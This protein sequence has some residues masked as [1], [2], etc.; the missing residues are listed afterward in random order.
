MQAAEKAE[1]REGIREADRFYA[2]ALE[3]LG[4]AETE[5]AAEVKLGRAKTLN[6][7]GD[8]QPADDLLVRVSD[9]APSLGR[10]DLHARALI[11]RSKIAQK[12]GRATEARTY[13]SA[14]EEIAGHVG[15]RLLQVRAIYV[16]AYIRAWFE[17]A[18]EAAVE[19]ARR[20]L[21][22][23]GELNDEALQIEVGVWLLGLLY[24]LGDLAG[25]EEQAMRCFALLGDGGGLRDKARLT[26]QLGQ[27]RYHQGEIDAAEELEERA[28]EWL[29]RTGDS[30]FYVQGLRILALCAVARSDLTLAE[31]RLR[32]A[33][34]YARE[35]G[36]S[37]VIDMYRCL[38]DVHIRQGRLSDAREI[39]E[40][41]ASN[42]PQEDS[43]A[44][45]A[46]LLIKANVT[47]VD[48][49]R[50]AA[51]GYFGEA[52]RLLEE[53]R[54]PL[55]L[56]EAR[57]SLA[58]ALRGFGDQLGAKAQL[59][60]AREAAARMGAQ[61]LVDDVDRELAIMRGGPVEP[62]PFAS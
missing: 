35:M 17:D 55:D 28:L 48:G 39:Q 27:I 45:A 7:L 14:A 51:I 41:A 4:G 36:H 47:A 10:A 16:G 25:A 53:Q 6:L 62:A 2:R 3:L 29:E 13:T 5:Q 43:Y 22:M 8:L 11:E 20:A 32:Q 60:T 26:F 44:R 21:A 19:D 34:P 59:E 40:L 18:G 9:G 15:D 37:M 33:I 24:N 38:A 31:E 54:L 49:P 12:R 56:A 57:L 61:A 46:V 23:A 30:I 52:L 50:E 42:V 58:R 1:R